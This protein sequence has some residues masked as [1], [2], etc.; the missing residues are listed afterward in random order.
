MAEYRVKDSFEL[1]GKGGVLLG[2]IVKGTVKVGMEVVSVDGAALDEV[3]TVSAV[4][5]ADDVGRKSFSIGLM[6]ERQP[7]KERL[8]KLFTLRHPDQQATGMAD[9]HGAIEQDRLYFCVNGGY[10][11]QIFQDL[12]ERLKARFGSVVSTARVLGERRSFGGPEG[13]RERVGFRRRH[14]VVPTSHRDLCLRGATMMLSLFNTHHVLAQPVCEGVP[15]DLT[16]G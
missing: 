9:A 8:D 6:F 13:L 1:T 11:A 12:L 7:T 16:G 10:G 3:L 15:V 14:C 4:E 2:H 5:I